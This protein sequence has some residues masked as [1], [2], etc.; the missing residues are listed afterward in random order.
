MRQIDIHENVVEPL[1][2]GMNL[3]EVKIYSDK[4]GVREAVL[5]KY[6]DPH[7]GAGRDEGCCEISGE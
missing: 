5:L 4:D 2:S 3:A 1:I 6:V 7:Y